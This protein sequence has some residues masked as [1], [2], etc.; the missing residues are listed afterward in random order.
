MKKVPQKEMFIIESMGTIINTE[1]RPLSPTYPFGENYFI[2]EMGFGCGVKHKHTKKRHEGIPKP[3]IFNEDRIVATLTVAGYFTL[4]TKFGGR[5]SLH[6]DIFYLKDDYEF[7][8]FI[9]FDD[10]DS[11]IGLEL[12]IP[13]ARKEFI[14]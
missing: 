3:K 14:L 2:T 10:H 4:R 5:F 7:V 6:T 13:G 1:P 9:E 8:R 11:I 12:F